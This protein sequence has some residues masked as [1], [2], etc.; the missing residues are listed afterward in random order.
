MATFIWCPQ[1][2]EKTVTPRVHTAQFGDGYAQRVA[3]GIN[4]Q[5]RE[6]SM[7]FAG[8]KSLIDSIESFLTVSGG[9][10]A[11]DWTDPDGLSGKWICESWKR[12]PRGNAKNAILSATFKQVYGE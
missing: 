8:N 5:T 9:V 7:T 3:D 2:A 4:N 12:S 6:W 10:T 1:T 11:F